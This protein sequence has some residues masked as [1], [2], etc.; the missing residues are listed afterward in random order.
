[1]LLKGLPGGTCGKEPACR[2][3]RPKR[4]RCWFDP[5]RTLIS[6]SPLDKNPMPGH[7]SE[8]HPVNEVHTKGQF[9]RASFGKNPRF[10]IQLEPQLPHLQDVSSCK[11]S[12]CYVPGTQEEL[13]PLAKLPVSP[14]WSLGPSH[15]RKLPQ[16]WARPQPAQGCPGLSHPY[17]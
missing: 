17:F 12:M 16:L 9:F 3:S 5:R 4:W 8:L 10:Q 15:T 11:K 2:C 14:A 6:R 13:S 7:L 1:M